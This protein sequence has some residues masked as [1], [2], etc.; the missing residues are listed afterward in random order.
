MRQALF[1]LAIV[2]ISFLLVILL[3]ILSVAMGGYLPTTEIYSIHGFSHIFFGIGLASII[4]SLRPRSTAR[5]VI[6]G[7]LLA[8]IVWE[9]HEGFWLAGEPIDSLEDIVLAILSASAFLY[10]KKGK[11]S[12]P[13]ST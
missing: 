11:N 5:V 8:G 7:V 4:L 3:E 12:E 10:L 2:A 1:Y 6:P 9:L 13:N